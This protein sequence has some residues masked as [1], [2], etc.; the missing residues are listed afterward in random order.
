MP[1]TLIKLPTLFST[2]TSE[3]LEQAKNLNIPIEADVE[4]DFI[5]INPI[6]I[7]SANSSA[8]NNATLLSVAGREGPLLVDLKLNEFL[9]YLSEQEY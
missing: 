6:Y 8:D 7:I 9:K 5:Y 3:E 1:S 2:V 4:E